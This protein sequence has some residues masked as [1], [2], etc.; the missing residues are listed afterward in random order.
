MPS[1]FITDF[2]EATENV[3]SPELFRRWSAIS[4]V[5]AAV[6]RRVWVQTG[7]RQTFPNLFI[8]LVA[9]PGIGKQVIDDARDLVA[10]LPASPL[11]V[12]PNQMTKASLVDE[13]VK[14]KSSVVPPG[15]LPV[16]YHSLYIL[17]EEVQVLMPSYDGDFLG[18]LNSLY[19][20]P[21]QPYTETRRTGSVREAKITLPQLNLL[22][23]VQPGWMAGTFPDLAWATGL[24][25]RV[26]MV[27]VEDQP[28]YD[29]FSEE[30]HDHSSRLG[31]LAGELVRLSRRYGPMK[32][33]PAALAKA[34]AWHLAGDEPKPVH[35]KL[36]FYT[37]RRPL[38]LTKLALVSA[39]S[40]GAPE[41]IEELDLD[42]AMAWLFEAERLM[43]DVFRAMTGRSD[44]AVIEELHY[45][46]SS[47]WRMSGG[48]PVH[49]TSIFSFLSDRVPSEKVEKLLTIAERSNVIARVAGTETYLPRPKHKHGME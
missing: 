49:E 23:G 48:K 7:A 42:R 38:H 32:W 6:E 30:E 12:S 10:G 5:G 44:Q 19:N 24:M 33:R 3:W 17:A 8:F 14:A 21:V 20:N 28:V 9:A 16:E 39:I 4:V 27:Y 2:M 13:L 22:A 35:S 11:R 25:S 41:W 15:G 43:P 26:I 29:L 18:V 34:R 36:Q 31:A 1:D 40:R 37:N 47:L 45:Y 46:V